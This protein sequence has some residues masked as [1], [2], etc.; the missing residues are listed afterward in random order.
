[1]AKKETVKVIADNGTLGFVGFVA[2]V[3]AVVYFLQGAKHG[4]DVI[5]AFIE[6]VVWPGVVVYYLL[7]GFGA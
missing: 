3:G 7:Q 6:A 1:M 5:W 4:G 2:Y